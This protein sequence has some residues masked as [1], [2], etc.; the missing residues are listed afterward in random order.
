[1]VGAL[2]REYRLH[3]PSTY[4]S[5]LKTALVLSFHGHGSTAILQEEQTGLSQL[6]D[7]RHFIAV[8]PQGVIG[9]DGQTGW[10]TARKKDPSVDDVGFVDRLLG[11][12]QRSFCIDPERIYATGFSNGGGMTAT[13]ACEFSGRIA[14]FAPV[15]GDYYP[16]PSGCHPNHPVS[17]LEIHGT[18]DTVN[19]YGGSADLRYPAVGAWLATWAQRDGCTVEPIVT[20]VGHGVTLQKWSSCSGNVVIMHYRLAGVGHIWPVAK[21]NNAAGPSTAVSFDAST[22]IWT[23]FSQRTLSM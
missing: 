17:L 19:A 4:Q 10:N 11:T 5:K 7:L 2:T 13:L 23:F 8:Y 14:A 1:V 18:A 20:E 3:L 16:Q 6:A 22:A 15:A 21:S 9:P 12:L